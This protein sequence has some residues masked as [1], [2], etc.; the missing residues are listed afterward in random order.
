M[1]ACQD[2]EASGIIILSEFKNADYQLYTLTE[3]HGLYTI[4][5]KASHKFM[6]VYGQS[7][8]KG[9]PII[10]FPSYELDCERFRI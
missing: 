1:Q 3:R 5:S 2:P 4:Q 8:E 9:A 10:E 7:K 6:S